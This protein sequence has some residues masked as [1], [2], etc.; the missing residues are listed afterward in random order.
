MEYFLSVGPIL[1]FNMQN[2]FTK[3]KQ[4][5]DR[6]QLSSVLT[7]SRSGLQTLATSK[8]PGEYF[9]TFISRPNFSDA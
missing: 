7:L 9:K 4:S 3:S 1:G 6:L 8:F 2:V 5:D